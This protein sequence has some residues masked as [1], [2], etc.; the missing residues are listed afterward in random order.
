MN[1]TE[2]LVVGAG[3]TGL[4][5]TTALLARGVDAI[6]VDK[7]P[8]GASTSRAAAV[9]ARTLEVLEDLDVSWRLVKNGLIAPR[10]SMRQR[11]STLIP[12]DFSALPTK[13]PYTLM[14]SQADTEQILAQRLSEMGGQAIRPKTVTA[15]AEHAHG[16]TATFDDGQTLTADYIVGADGMHSTV[17]EHAGIGFAGG[18]FAECFALADVRVTGAA[19]REEVILFY[20]RDGLT[21]LAPLPGGIYRIVAPAADAPREPTAEFAQHLLDTRGYGPGRT[22]VTELLWGSRFRIQHRVADRY[23]NGRLILAGDAAH[24]HSPAGGQGMNLGITDAIGL[25][26]ALTDVLRGDSEA[27]LDAYGATQRARAQQV[28]TLTGR[29][30][31]IS[32]LPRPLRPIRNSALRVAAQIP[33]VRRQLAWRLSGLVYR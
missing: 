22:V 23:R 24:V 1:D 2:V 5:L 17:R 33:A 18:E 29:L 19:P 31:R 13:Y 25:A 8:A 10:F 7:L 26:N 14:I 6:L 21:V 16:V 15:L 30:T 28:L 20:G 4:T 11:A 27:V 32:T 12:I 3:P 9:N